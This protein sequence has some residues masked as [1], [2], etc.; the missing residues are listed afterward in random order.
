MTSPLS[1][2][3]QRKKTTGYL[4]TNREPYC[5][6]NLRTLS[7]RTPSH[8]KAYTKYKYSKPIKKNSRV[9][10]KRFRKRVN[11]ER[12]NWVILTWK[13]KSLV[14]LKFE[15]GFRVIGEYL[16]Q[17]DSILR[18]KLT[19]YWES[20]WLDIESQIDSI[21]RVKLT[22]YWESNWLDI[23]SQ[24]VHLSLNIESNY[25]KSVRI[26]VQPVT[27][28]FRSKWLRFFFQWGYFLRQSLRI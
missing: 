25:S 8:C 9:G 12:K 1:C 5:N 24:I 13:V 14:E 21:L 10:R 22:R 23:E 17:I 27:L 4:Q 16:S 18:V 26:L 19:R 3:G 11:T 28:L 6:Y 2:L 7:N 15:P 20:N